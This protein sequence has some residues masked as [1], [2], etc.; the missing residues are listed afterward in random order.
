MSTGCEM[1]ARVGVPVCVPVGA[2]ACAH[3]YMR[4]VSGCMR[5]PCRY[6]VRAVPGV[7]V[8]VWADVEILRNV[9]ELV[10]VGK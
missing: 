5:V 4:L 6:G 10:R 2:C 9:G 1:Y 3:V 7:M 8:G